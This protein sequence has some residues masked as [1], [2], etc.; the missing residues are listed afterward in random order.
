MVAKLTSAFILITMLAGSPVHAHHAFV[1]VFDRAQTV[2]IEGEIVD[3]AWRNPHIRFTLKVVGQDGRSTDWE[4][5]GNQKSM[6]ARMGVTEDMV[7]VGD[8][9]R[10]AGNPAHRD[11]NKM[12]VTNI[13]LP[14]GRELVTFTTARPRWSDRA[15]G[16]DSAWLQ[17]GTA[18]DAAA[19]D[20]GIFRIGSSNLADPGSFPIWNREYPLTA[21][22]GEKLEAWRQNSHV[23]LSCSHY[24][25]PT[26]MAAPDP[27]AFYDRGNS[28]LLRLE[29]FNV[30]RTIHMQSDNPSTMRNPSPLGYSTGKWDGDAL[31]IETS[32]INWHH[33][34]QIGIS[35]SNDASLIERFTPSKDG[36]RLNYRL[37]VS[38]PVTFTEPAVLEKHWVWR[39]DAKL[40]RYTDDDDCVQ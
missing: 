25:M 36:S 9:V 1:A 35:L 34:D 31:I 20:R 39:P 18:D 30:E 6:L 24:G 14:D 26:I 2:E 3:I 10:M 22:A 17:G 15:V 8:Q 12:F 13:L 19:S 4:I 28:V 16:H 5:E 23:V 11:Q 33:F 21:A 37:T 32:N 40:E 27:I 29:T 38:D 7:N